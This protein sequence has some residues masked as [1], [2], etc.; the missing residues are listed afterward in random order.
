V[1][2]ENVKA[3][4]RTA[5]LN[6]PLQTLPFGDDDSDDIRDRPLANGLHRL[7]QGERTSGMSKQ[8]NLELF[9][10]AWQKQ[11]NLADA[12]S[13]VYQVAMALTWYMNRDKRGEA[14]AGFGRLIR[15]TNLGRTTVIRAIQ[16]LETD[17]LRQ[18]KIA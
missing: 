11:I 6:A 18:E 2:G 17:R 1:R 15:D 7:G 5:A 12:P 3:R 16:W 9:R 13:S 10:E 14:F 4:K 8:F